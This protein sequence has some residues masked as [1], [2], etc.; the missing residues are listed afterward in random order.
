MEVKLALCVLVLTNYASIIIFCRVFFFNICYDLLSCLNHVL[1][2][3]SV[4]LFPATVYL[5]VQHEP[6]AARHSRQVR[7]PGLGYRLGLVL[8]PLLGHSSTHLCHRRHL[9]GEI[10][11]TST[12]KPV[13]NDILK[14]PT[15]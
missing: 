5:D 13:F 14:P 10:R 15:R 2:M 3:R 6:A 9:P 7:V 4:C 11:N 12:G 8:R 1:T